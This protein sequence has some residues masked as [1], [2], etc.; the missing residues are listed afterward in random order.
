MHTHNVIFTLG[1]TRPVPKGS[2][3]S[4]GRRAGLPRQGIGAGRC[5]TDP[6]W[7]RAVA[8]GA[9]NR[10]DRSAGYLRQRSAPKV[11][12]CPER[13][14]LRPCFRACLHR[15][16]PT[17][18]VRHCLASWCGTYPSPRTVVIPRLAAERHACA[19]IAGEGRNEEV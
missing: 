15:R 13:V 8:P 5:G 2:Y 3:P 18:L 4:A 7:T 10:S 9:N 16:K 17:P 12:G 14:A 19:A 1:G 11:H 6:G